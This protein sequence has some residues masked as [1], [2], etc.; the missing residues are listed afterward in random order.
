VSR[1]AKLRSWVRAIEAGRRL[2]QDAA[3]ADLRQFERFVI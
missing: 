1:A 3:E 2:D